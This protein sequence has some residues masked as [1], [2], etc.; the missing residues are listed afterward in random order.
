MKVKITMRYHLTSSRM[1]I[2]KK[3]TN[4]Q[5]QTMTSV[6]ERVEKFE[7]LCTAVETTKWYNYIGKQHGGTSKTKTRIMI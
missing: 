6:G 3:Q 5:K 1:V 7:P 4:T 2:I